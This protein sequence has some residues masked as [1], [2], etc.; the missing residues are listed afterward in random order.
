MYETFLIILE[1]SLLHMPLIFGAYISMSL[2]KLPDLSLESSYACGALLA[3]ATMSTV[4]QAIPAPLSLIVTITISLTGGALVGIMISF[5]TQKCHIP[6]LLSSLITTGLFHGIMQLFAGVYVSLNGC[7]SLLEYDLI[8]FHAELPSIIIISMICFL[9]FFYF[10]K[11]EI[12]YAFTTFGNNP[13]FFT[14]YSIS[15]AYIFIFGVIFAHA[16]SGL[17]GYLCAQSQGFADISMG[18]GKLLLSIT[19]LTL[20]KIV[21]V[22]HPT[23]I[24]PLVGLFGYFTLQQ[25]LLKIGFDLRYFTMIQATV[26]V[27]VLIVQY[28]KKAT[29]DHNHLG[30]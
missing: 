6:Y 4:M 29:I 13:L 23:I 25:L 18:F 30:I 5:L 9:F 1:Q 21:P 14:H 20:G 7:K 10:F 2:M 24:F 28:R 17:S 8:P 19:A 15:T 22:K 26:I 16:L 27:T 12:I 3:A 11:T